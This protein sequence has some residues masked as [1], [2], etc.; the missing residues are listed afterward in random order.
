MRITERPGLETPY[1][2][3]R[4]AHQLRDAWS[5]KMEQASA[6]LLSGTKAVKNNGTDP[7]VI[8]A[9]QTTLQSVSVRP[10]AGISTGAV[11]RQPMTD[12][13]STYCFPTR[14]TAAQE[15]AFS[16]GEASDTDAI[17][18]ALPYAMPE[19]AVLKPTLS[20]SA[21]GS[22]P[23]MAGGQITAQAA[24]NIVPGQ[25][26][27]AVEA[28]RIN[29]ALLPATNSAQSPATVLSSSTSDATSAKKTVEPGD[30]WQTRNIHMTQ[31]EQGHIH[32]WLRDAQVDVAQRAVLLQQI[33]QQLG[34]VGLQ[35]G[36]L[37]V[38]GK[39]VWLD[40]AAQPDAIPEQSHSSASDTPASR[41]MSS[42]I[43]HSTFSQ[44][45]R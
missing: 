21:I 2:T 9:M 22:V 7:L 35:L 26:P 4:D 36:S 14:S 3:E 13:A 33:R 17:P 25:N 20:G 15:A 41:A 12:A 32:A 5:R 38:N 31:D 39:Q 29:R 44:R 10:S 11:S 34:G 28:P 37:T 1:Q 16:A 24:A 40:H 18:T 27:H 43:N 23:A 45:Q 19:A 42:Y 8:A 6:G 30:N